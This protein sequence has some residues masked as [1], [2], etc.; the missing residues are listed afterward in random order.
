MRTPRQRTQQGTATLLLALTLLV[1]GTLASA[2]SSRAVL[3]D[4]LVSTARAQ[5]LQAHHAA[6]AA[7]ATVQAGVLA[8]FERSPALDPFADLA[9]Q[10]TC[11]APLVGPRWQCTHWPLPEGSMPKGWQA[12]A[13]MARDL[14][15]SPHVW[16]LHALAREGSGRAQAQVQ[17]SLWVPAL[18]P[19]AHDTPAAALLLNGCFGE[20]SA[21]AWRFCPAVASGV[22]CVGSS[23]APA[24]L[25]FWA[26]DSDKDGKLS[27]NERLACLPIGPAHL[28]GGG[29]VTGPDSPSAR[30]PCSRA[31]WRS[32]F[33]DITPEQLRAWSEAQARNGLHGQSQPARSVYWIDSPADWTQT[34]GQ[35]ENPVLLVFS[36]QSCALRCPRIAA[37]VQ[38]HGTVFVDA[39]CDDS[40]M[41][42]WQAGTIDGLLA[43]EAGLPAPAG[44]GLVRARHYAR[45][46]FA[47]HW[48]QG[49]DA[50]QVQRAAGSHREGAP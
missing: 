5:A 26:N 43:I 31:V 28:P 4:L 50:R 9:Q 10:L 27:V 30:S 8:L 40:K 6:R 35:P 13:W 18:L 15:D 20:A 21:S 11:P 22:P 37:G 38:I 24:V 45:S 7:L 23:T 44:Q 1:L 48:P 25:G 2:W 36:A 49:I 29:T 33:G 19:P 42:D 47:L 34:L 16:Q 12:Q 46:A 3:G 17:E 39:G 14:L 41:R 32:V